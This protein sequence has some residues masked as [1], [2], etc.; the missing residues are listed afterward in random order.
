MKS[1]EGHGRECGNSRDSMGESGSRDGDGD[2]DGK[3]NDMQENSIDGE[4]NG[5]DGADSRGNSEDN[6]SERENGVGVFVPKL[7]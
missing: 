7:P 6:G 1:R 5:R 2:G 4:E 3:E